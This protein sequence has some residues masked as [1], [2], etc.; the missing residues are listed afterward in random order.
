ME[1]SGGRLDEETYHKVT[2][3]GEPILD[4]DGL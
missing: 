1:C 2:L 3:D 4:L